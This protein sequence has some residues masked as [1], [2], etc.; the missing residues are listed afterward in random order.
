MLAPPEAKPVADDDAPPA[1]ALAIRLGPPIADLPSLVLGGRRSEHFP[2]VECRRY[3]GIA[4][5][6]RKPYTR[7]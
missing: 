5:P 1:A 3:H 7:T 4:C 2:T 6:A